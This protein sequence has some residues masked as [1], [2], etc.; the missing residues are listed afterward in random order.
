[1]FTFDIK[2]G[3]YYIQQFRLSRKRV[4]GKASGWEKRF[5]FL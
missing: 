1:M 4:P 5:H 2:L 3:F